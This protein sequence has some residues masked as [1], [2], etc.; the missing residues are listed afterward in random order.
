MDL[1][2]TKGPVD[3]PRLLL[4]LVFD[5]DSRDVTTF[6]DFQVLFLTVESGK[7]NDAMVAERLDQLLTSSCYVSC[8]GLHDYEHESV[9]FIS[10]T[11]RLWETSFERVD[12]VKCEMFHIPQNRKIHPKHHLYNMCA[13]ARK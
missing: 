10:K 5:P 7:Y 9:W 11:A 2:K 6:Y 12:S 8:P 1:I 13:F 4:T 3:S